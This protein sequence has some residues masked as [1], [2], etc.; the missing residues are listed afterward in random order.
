MYIFHFKCSNHIHR[1]LW[2]IGVSLRNYVN[3]FVDN[4]SMINFVK[5][6][7]LSTFSLTKDLIN[8]I[9]DCISPSTQLSNIMS[10]H[11]SPVWRRSSTVP[12]WWPTRSAPCWG[13]SSRRLSSVALSWNCCGVTKVP[14]WPWQRRLCRREKHS[15]S[16]N[17]ATS[18]GWEKKSALKLFMT[19]YIQSSFA[20]FA[21]IFHYR[22]SSRQ[23]GRLSLFSR[24][25]A[26][27]SKPLKPS[28]WGC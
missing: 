24:F 5:R 15:P 17:S 12:G 6:L 23:R 16:T 21:D 3:R 11:G 8:S 28:P 25:S 2:I 1:P 4:Y 20:T 10:F 19:T 22:F 27:H 18:S 13:C 14:W 7:I 9:L 26:T